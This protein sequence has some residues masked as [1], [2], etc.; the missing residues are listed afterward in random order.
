MYNIIDSKEVWDSI[1]YKVEVIT[2]E[3]LLM[4]KYENEKD[5]KDIHP[6]IVMIDQDLNVLI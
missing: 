6:E 5:N 2:E 3:E 1:F 4:D